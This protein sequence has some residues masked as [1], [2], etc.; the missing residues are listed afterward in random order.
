MVYG[1]V[2]GGS[3]QGKVSIALTGGWEFEVD[4]AAMQPY[5][6]EP[7][8]LMPALEASL[9]A[10]IA[11]V[12]PISAEAPAGDAA[13]VGRSGVAASSRGTRRAPV[14]VRTPGAPPL[15]FPRAA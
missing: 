9:R 5:W 7:N 12:V 1:H 14:A 8:A 10:A 11:D 4:T 13:I 15:R 2:R 6:Q 3:V